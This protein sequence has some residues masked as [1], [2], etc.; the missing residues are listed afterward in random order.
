MKKFHLTLL[1]LMLMTAGIPGCRKQPEQATEELYPIKINLTYIP[2]IQFAPLYVAIENGYFADAGLDVSLNYGNEADLMALVGAG[3]QR[4]MI[5]SGEQVLLSRA[6]GLPLVYVAA[7]YKDYPVG[8]VSLM[9]AGIKTPQDLA[10]KT[11]GIPGL[12][13][14][15]YIGFEA[16]RKV[17]GLEE[18]DLTLNSIGYTQVESLTSH[19]ADA[20]V[21][22]V[23]NE[24]IV[25]SSLG[26]EVNVLRVSDYLDL[27]GNGLVTNEE[28]IKNDPELVQS[29]VDALLKGILDCAAEP[30]EA[31]EISKAYVENLV[32]ADEQTQKAILAASIDLWQTDK[33]G[34][35]PYENWGNMQSLL[36][37][38]GLMK[39]P[40]ELKEAFSND[41]VE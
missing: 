7:W 11:V 13:G 1:V 26:Y 15:N 4:F 19:M 3:D 33:P 8:V 12:Y 17:A 23:A 37:E 21:I 14:A 22:Y 5:A 39:A 34:Y 40:V 10:G 24:P 31:F 27:V 6:Q 38:I 35:S 9:D 29:V 18:A 25:L 20:V 28:T 2:N 16:L 36:L 41:F 32:N 30:D